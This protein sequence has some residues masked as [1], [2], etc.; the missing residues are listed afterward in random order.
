[1]D[2]D[3]DVIPLVYEECDRVRDGHVE[4]RDY[5]LVFDE[6]RAWKGW[7]SKQ[8]VLGTIQR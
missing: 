2:E 8:Y 4:K 3:G 5:V 7:N 6:E 1:M